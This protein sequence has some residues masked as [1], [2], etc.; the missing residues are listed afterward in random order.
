MLQEGTKAP[1]FSAQDQTG[2]T[3]TLADYKGKWLLLYFYPKDDTPGC[4]KEACTIRDAY[5]SFSDTG[6]AVLGVSKDTVASHE[7]FAKKYDLPFP[8]LADPDKQII[9]AYEALGT[10]SMFGKTYEGTLR[11]SY[12]INPE[13]IIAKAY[14]KVKPAEHAG[15]VLTDT[16]QLR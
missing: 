12:L 2:N 8:I 16:E 4:T 6:L 13:G 3:H 5:S 9:K 7:K 11:I 14:E 10:K 15:E 1:A